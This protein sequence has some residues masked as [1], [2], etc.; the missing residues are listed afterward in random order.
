MKRNWDVVR[1][2]LLAIEETSPKD[3][4]R[5]AVGDRIREKFDQKEVSHRDLDHHLVLLINEDFIHGSIQK[6]IGHLPS[7]FPGQMKWKGLDLLDD[8]RDDGIWKEVKSRASKAGGTLSLA[9][10]KE[11]AKAVAKATV[12]QGLM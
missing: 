8:I 3:D 6:Y 1:E 10:L 2:I 12:T 11:L 7:I 4:V 9:V 5:R